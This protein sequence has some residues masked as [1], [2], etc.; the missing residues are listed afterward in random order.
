MAYRDCLLCA[1]VTSV[2]RGLPG[3][4]AASGAR[5]GLALLPSALP[6]AA[7]LQMVV[8]GYEAPVQQAGGDREGVVLFLD[9]RPFPSLL[10]QSCDLVE[11]RLRSKLERTDKDDA[12]WHEPLGQVERF[13]HVRPLNFPIGR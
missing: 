10:L 3:S 13:A 4:T 5:D 2:A 8:Q 6:T 1:G 7:S 9:G 11:R 12:G